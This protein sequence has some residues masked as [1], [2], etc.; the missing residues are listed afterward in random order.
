M[1]TLFIVYIL[2][3]GFWIP[4][5]MLDGWGSISY[6][7]E[8]I[9]LERKLYAEESLIRLKQIDPRINDKKFQCVVNKNLTFQVK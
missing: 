4:G 9:C 8:E 5:D 7:T 1:K 3:N 6:E 2:I